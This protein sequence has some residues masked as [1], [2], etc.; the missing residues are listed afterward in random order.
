VGG[1]CFGAGQV[2]FALSL[3]SL[4]MGIAF[5]INIGLGT[6]LGFLLPLLT[7]HPDKIWTQSG[8]MSLL[9]ICCIILSLC[10]SY[11]AG[12]QRDKQKKET[13]ETYQHQTLKKNTY[14][15]GVVLAILAGV[16]SGGQNY[17]FALTS[18][19]QQLALSAG[20]NSWVAAIIMWPPFLVCAFIPYLSY[21]LYLHVKKASFSFYRKSS[22][23]RNY[24]L[25]VSTSIIWFCGLFLYSKSS[26]LIGDLG[27]VLTWPLSMSLIILTSNFWSW[28]NREWAGCRLAVKRNAI[29]SIVVLVVAVAILAYSADL[30]S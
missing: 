18:D 6:A 15:L 10:I 9:G 7:L 17:T 30:S 25:V 16:F 8:V 5:I 4:G 26:M 1:F 23:L 29:L 21:M 12:S 14:I 3:K 13:Q 27:P 19:M 28:R 2:C 22:F 24:S 20:A 11:Y